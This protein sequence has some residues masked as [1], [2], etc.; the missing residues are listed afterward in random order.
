MSDEYK[1]VV[2]RIQFDVQEGNAGGKTVRRLPVKVAGPQQ[3]M[4]T[5][6]LWPEHAGVVVN[7]G[8]FIMAEGKFSSKVA[9]KKD[10]SEGT[11]Y[12]LSA[13]DVT[14]LPAAPKSTRE[15]VNRTPAA[16]SDDAPF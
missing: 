5:V 2:G 4:V 8:D 12:D 10:G 7:K 14:V 1:L 3:T 11:F 13:T 6:T 16:S 15:V 9:Q